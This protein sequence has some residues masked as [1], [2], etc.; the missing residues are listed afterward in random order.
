MELRHLRYFIA[1]AEDLSFSRAAEQLHIAEPPLSRQIRQLEE[2]LD[3]QL[4]LRDRRRVVLTDAGAILLKEAKI[5][6]AQTA[7]LLDSIRQVKKGVAGRVRVGIGTGMADKV[8]RVLMEHSKRF[9]G[10][11]I[12]CQDVYST[13]QNE[14]LRERKI[15]VGFLRPWIDSTHL[16]SEPLFKEPFVV[17][18]SKSSPFAKR[19]KVQLKHIAN[20][21]VLLHVRDFSSG[22]YDKVVELYRKAGIIPKIAQRPPGPFEEARTILIASG[23]AVYIGA[24]TVQSH[25]LYGSKLTTVPLDE[26]DAAI[27]VHIAWRQGEK[28][29]VI[30]AFLESARRV[31]KHAKR[32]GYPAAKSTGGDD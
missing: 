16:V 5:L 30:L 7:H 15:D 11:E 2:E 23:K 19:K 25:L 13:L 22:M 14:A 24:G 3:V 31:F 12:E 20:D 28:S 8:H 18:L 17:L 32:G 9:P 1:V 10:V 21:P 26:P 6:T 4:F 27:D 29:A